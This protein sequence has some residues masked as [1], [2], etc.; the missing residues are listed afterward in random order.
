MADANIYSLI[1]PA[2]QAQDPL[3]Q[4]GRALSIKQLM[5]QQGLQE[6][7][8]R[9]LTRDIEDEDALRSFLR[10]KPNATPEEVMAVS[11]EFGLKYG[12]GK[13][14]AANTQASIDKTRME[15]LGKALS[16]N[17]D[18]LAGVNDPQAAAQWVIASYNDPL[19]SPILQRTGS[20]EE[21]IARI[22]QDPQGFQQWKM[23]NGL[24]IEKIMEMTAPK[25]SMVNTGKQTIPVEGN[26]LAPGYSAAPIQMT[27]TPGQDQSNATTIEQGNLNRGVT[28]RGQNMV[29]SRTRDTADR[30]EWQYDEARGLQV[31][32]RTGEA[33]PVM[34]NGQPIK[35]KDDAPEAMLKAAGYADRMRKASDL[36]DRFASAGKPGVTESVAGAVPLAGNLAANMARSPERQQYYQAAEDWVRAKLRQES[37]AVIADEEMAREIRVYFPQIGD[38]PE[39]IRQ[40]AQARKTAEQ[41]MVTAAG[42]GMRNAQP[43]A[44]PL[45]QRQP[46]REEIDAELRRRGVIKG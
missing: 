46:T 2:A 42:R 35:P 36:L 16:M 43:A 5:G 24:G 45:P 6:L 22:P 21:A 7:Q 19:L 34:Q 31:N 41:A 9:K 33:R 3:E 12:K 25:I 30:G 13:L 14:D 8:T 23:K 40:K 32:K 18:L 29:D 15:T 26:P 44:S 4:Y 1:R 27:T 38:S 28:I 39:V 10:G 20:P 11:P 37:G 17:R